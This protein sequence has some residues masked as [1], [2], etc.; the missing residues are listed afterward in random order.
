M[1]LIQPHTNTR[2]VV[3]PCVETAVKLIG[4]ET[5]NLPSPYRSRRSFD[6]LFMKKLLLILLLL[7]I[8]G[9]VGF[10]TYIYL[11]HDGTK[12]RDRASIEYPL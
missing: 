2:E 1:D 5:T 6:A 11:Q 4:G 9:P 10:A 8:I 7:R 12:T 3:L